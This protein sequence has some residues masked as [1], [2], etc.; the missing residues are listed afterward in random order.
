MCNP[1]GTDARRDISPAHHPWI[2]SLVI[3]AS[4]VLAGMAIA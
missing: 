3:C 2:W 4:A 1:Y